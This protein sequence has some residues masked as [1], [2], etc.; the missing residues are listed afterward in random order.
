MVFKSIIDVLV[1]SMAIN[2]GSFF[3]GQSGSGNIIGSD[4][5]LFGFSEKY[6]VPSSE[7]C[8]MKK[9][10]NVTNIFYISLSYV[11][12]AISSTEKRQLKTQIHLNH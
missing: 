12:K 2:A 6:I 11:N 4:I 5:S 7:T 10:S 9:G 8:V 3:T 1:N